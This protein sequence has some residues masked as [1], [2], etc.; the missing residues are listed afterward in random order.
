MLKSI[1]SLFTARALSVALVLEVG[2][3][4]GLYVGKT[5]VL[6]PLQWA[7]AGV[8]LLGSSLL[9]AM[10]H[11]WPRAADRKASASAWARD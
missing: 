6:S 8:A 5:G 11:A 1:R 2:F 4:T 9:A 7:G 10:V 3:I